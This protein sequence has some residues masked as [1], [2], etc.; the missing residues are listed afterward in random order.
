VSLRPDPDLVAR[1]AG[2]VSLPSGAVGIAV[3]GGPDSLALLLLAAAAWPGR[4]IAATVDHRLRAESA[5]EAAFVAEICV[6]LGVDHETLVPARPIT[7]S[8]QAAAR[9]ARYALLDTWRA[10]R[11]AGCVMTAHHAD[12]QAETLLMRLNRGAGLGGLAGIRRVNGAVVRPLLGWRRVDLA[13]IV[14][15][16]GL[17]PV[18]DPS[19]ADSRFD[20]VRIRAALADAEWIDIDGVAAS[21]G[22]LADAEAALDWMAAR[23]AGERVVADGEA[24]LVDPSDLPEALLRRVMLGAIARIDPAAEP[25]GPALDRL[26]STLRAGDQASIGAALC[27]GGDRWRVAPAPPRRKG[28]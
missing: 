22:H 17:V 26:L 20:R 24:L 23:L 2:G 15:A 12:D 7:G 6:R 11:G 19:N 3:S 21:A 18:D 5:D 10:R 1:F 16:A 27:R 4:V 28:K 14:A 8:L 9:G 13:A 25:S